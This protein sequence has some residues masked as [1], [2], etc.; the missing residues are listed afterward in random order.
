MKKYI[1]FFISIGL[2]LG[3]VLFY[4]TMS[5][6]Q[7]KKVTFNESGYILNN[8]T[9][10]YYF[11][12]DETYT[13]SYNDKIVFYDTEGTK[14]TLDNDNF[15]HYSSGNIVGLQEGV[16]LELSKIDDN[17]I[18]Y[19]NIGANKEIKKVSNR[20]IVKNLD[21]DLQFEQAIWKISSTKYIILGNNIRIKLENG[22]EKEV[23]GYVEIEY[24]DNEII[25]I[26]NQEISYQTI[27]SDSYIELDNDIKINLGTKIVSK[28]DENKMSLEDMVI[29]SD[30]NVTLVDLN[31]D[32]E[33]ENN[34]DEDNTTE[35]NLE[36]NSVTVQQGTG[37]T[38]TSSSNSSST[39]NSGSTTINQ[40]TGTVQDGTTGKDENIID[41]QT[42]DIK[43]DKT[44]G[45]ETEIDSSKVLDEPK[46]KIDNM[47]VTALSVKGTIKITDDNDLLSKDEDIHM[48]IIN[49]NT[50]KTIYNDSVGYGTL[51]IPLNVE[52]LL[53]NTQYTLI[54]SAT[55]IV[56][57]VPYTKNFIYKTFVT[58]KIGIDIERN[59]FTDD[60]LN[61]SV[62][63]DDE[64][65][66][67]A[68]ITILDANGNELPNREKTIENTNNETKEVEFDILQ[69]DT[70]YKIKIYDIQ[71]NG[72]TQTSSNWIIYYDDCKTLKSK[73]SIDMLNY[74]IDK[75][76]GKFKLYIEKVTDKNNSIQNYT[77]NIYECKTVIDEHGKEN[78]QPDTSKPVYTRTTTDKEITVDVK[79]ANSEEGIVRDKY[80]VF[81]VVAN[82]YD[83]EKYVESASKM[84]GNFVL[85][86]RTFPTVKFT[87]EEITATSIKGTLYISDPDNTVVIDEENPLSV[88]YKNQVGD[89]ETFITV[90]NTDTISIEEDE[91]GE[92][93]IAIPITLEG[94]KAETSYVF[95]AY[96]T[97]E[98]NDGNSYTPPIFI[99]SAIVNTNSYKP[100]EVTLNVNDKDN[101]T[102]AIG[103]N[104][105]GEEFEEESLE[106]VAFIMQEG[107]RDFNPND[108]YWS[109]EVNNGNYKE[110]DKNA[111]SLKDLLCGENKLTIT[112][113]IIGGGKEE[114]Y[115][116]L[117][118]V[119]LVTV[120]VDGTKYLNNIPIKAEKNDEN[121]TGMTTFIDT[122]NIVKTATKGTEYT[123]AYIM[124]EGKGTVDSIPTE[125]ENALNV[126][127]I[128][129]NIA[130]DY[131]LQDNKL[132]DSTIVGY[133]IEAKPPK[134]SGSR[135]KKSITY[136]VWDKNG[137]PIEK[138]GKQ[139]TRTVEFPENGSIPSAVFEV[140]YGTN[141]TLD[142]DNITGLHRGGAYYFSYTVTYIGEDGR[143]EI[144]PT[145]S[146]PTMNEKS[147][148]SE[149]QY[150]DKQEPSFVMY[151]KTSDETSMTYIY[152]C[153]DYD[154]ALNYDYEDETISSL[155][156]NT[157]GTSQGEYQININ[158]KDNEIT[159]RSLDKGYTY[160]IRYKK[161]L[162]K[163]ES[164]TYIAETLVTQKF[165]GITN[166]GNIT[167]NASYNNEKNPNKLLIQL[168]GASSD[169][170]RVAGAKVALTFEENRLETNLL[171]LKYDK[172]NDKYSIEVDLISLNLNAGIMGKTI[173]VTVSLYYDNGKTGYM[174]DKEE[175]IEY[176][177]SYINTSNDYRYMCIDEQ[178]NF[179][180]DSNYSINGNAY[181]YVLDTQTSNEFA[182]LQITD[183][184]GNVKTLELKYTDKG[185]MYGDNIIVQKNLAGEEIDTSN[186]HKV[187]INAII[188]GIKVI[189]IETTL[190]DA[191][192]KAELNNP[193]NLNFKDNKIYIELF[194]STN[195]DDIPEDWNNVNTIPVSLNE[196]NKFTLDGI[197]PAN[198]YKMRF[199]YILDGDTDYTYM[200]D[201][202]TYTIKKV[203]EFET[204][205]T[206]GIENVNV[207]YEANTYRDKYLKI[208][209]NVDSKR[210]YMYSH[211]K[212]EFYEY[213]DSTK[214]YTTKMNLKEENICENAE[215]G[216]TYE[217]ING[218]LYVKNAIYDKEDK[219]F[220]TVLEKI[221]IGPENNIFTFGK[222]YKLVITPIAY[223]KK[224][225]K[226]VLLEE[227]EK[228]QRLNGLNN[229]E[230]GIK[231]IR[232]DN[233]IVTS[234]TITD[235][236]N[237]IVGDA[238]VSDKVGVG[239][240]T[241][242]IFKYDNEEKSNKQEVTIS[243]S[244]GNNIS[245]KTFNIKE[246]TGNFHFYIKNAD[247]SSYYELEMYYTIDKDN[248]SETE[249][250]SEIKTKIVKP[251]NNNIDLGTM[252]VAANEKESNKIDLKFYNT[253]NIQ[254]IDGIEY[255]IY[256]NN[257][258]YDR[259][260]RFIPIWN[261]FNNDDFTGGD[262]YITLPT[263]LSNS[264]TYIITVNFYKGYVDENNKGTHVG[265]RETTYTYLSGK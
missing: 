231:M 26:Y 151:P 89:E 44:D 262:F 61:F 84:S 64:L 261:Q 264:G 149:I 247:F 243:D 204:L 159:F 153:Y 234:I 188:A 65:I 215:S 134:E 27:S 226:E 178:G 66:K 217:I 186:E 87:Q 77:Y 260:E 190:T 148:K 238:I 74:T 177:V 100:L 92:K 111:E 255:T 35:N 28:K 219:S 171:E 88:M 162:N 130:K 30:D 228:K 180:E 207:E 82:S 158:V 51:S 55:Y 213:D 202:D 32:K 240:Y 117:N 4:N 251:I 132:N 114:D 69:S 98:L 60:S 48:K 31:N 116:E 8:S 22:T 57:E 15:I 209:Y 155:E 136:Y 138:D 50:G 211:T 54:V 142:K 150:P 29:N 68:K 83:N 237:I 141:E 168:S 90:E 174:P 256:D 220:D 222:K 183:M 59:G 210:S 184:R 40:G 103:V 25:N 250:A 195:K 18:I 71:Y 156:L 246:H 133:K 212:Y 110:L 179:V 164:S 42:P 196:E 115:T 47:E 216:N 203:Y 125:T 146:D 253:Y 235:N 185:F 20:Y 75:R 105:K 99:G 34:T 157:Q 193:L 161:R 91:N 73:A 127:A 258:N 123:A 232:K 230:V 126:T 62:S 182:Y 19:Y 239:T 41:I 124:V 53:P 96:G 205:A 43:Y 102:F 194:G 5:V 81:Q 45:N 187:T 224:E 119:V 106:S 101:S 109:R 170:K 252:G 139:L 67:G 223:N 245:T 236:D 145:M 86:G 165:D 208:T 85:S 78:L 192:I 218:D 9:E 6:E 259:T 16:L 13:T 118:Y 147:L 97:V 175:N 191:V 167:Y 214:D 152:S 135:K 38:S 39:S 70:Q 242:K 154:K 176:Y 137:N 199:K 52:T 172:T 23:Q 7:S 3:I 206:I 93:V 121:K 225:E 46:F 166:L 160:E 12:Q 14:V 233:D 56:N 95:S 76:N 94:L 1:M 21:K 79:D 181:Q 72:A 24:S 198:Y 263:E 249:N 17:P 108:K 2:L 36:E 221:N 197:E 227:F 80:Y 241:L 200:Y 112:P 49:N 248:K 173:D 129:N 163:A 254:K 107:S 128:T 131:Q 58:S 113:S 189:N 122:Q 169:L 201:V 104:L 143:E 37:S 257:N 10:R 244:S 63:F 120:T 229:P 144:W 265:N 33:D 11:Y 140:D